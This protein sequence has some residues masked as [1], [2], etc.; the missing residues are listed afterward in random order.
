M[1]Y[2]ILERVPLYLYIYVLFLVSESESHWR[3]SPF[4]QKMAR[5]V[6]NP[7]TF[8]TILISAQGVPYCTNNISLLTFLGVE[9]L[10]IIFYKNRCS[11]KT[12]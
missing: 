12:Q 10:Q 11:L 6:L 7:R 4:C 2:N 1:F 3:T 9:Q 8:Y 5:A